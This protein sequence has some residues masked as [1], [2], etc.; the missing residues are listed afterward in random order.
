MIR[1]FQILQVKIWF[2]N[3]RSK[4]KK[5]LKSTGPTGGSTGPPTNSGNGQNLGH[6]PNA[7]TPQTPPETPETHSPPSVGPPPSLLAGGTQGSSL[8][9]P[10]SMS[11]AVSPPA[12]SPP[13]TS[14]D[15]GPAKAAAMNSYIPQYSWYHHGHDPSINQQLLT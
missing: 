14:W 13:I 5:M 9:P 12:M 3:R 10:N 4:Y 7:S 2:Q 15:M 6:P 1:L 11:S 8:V